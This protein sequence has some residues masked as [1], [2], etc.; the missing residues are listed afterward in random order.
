MVPAL[1][2]RP[3]IS[4]GKKKLMWRKAN[5][6]FTKCKPFIVKPFNLKGKNYAADLLINKAGKPFC[7]PA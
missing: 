1:I 7:S 3:F 2:L 6:R 4:E 5:S